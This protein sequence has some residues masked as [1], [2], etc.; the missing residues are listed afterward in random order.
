MRH[1]DLDCRNSLFSVE[2]L[3]IVETERGKEVSLTINHVRTDGSIDHC[4]FIFLNC[5]KIHRKNHIIIIDT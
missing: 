4:Q 5:I 2:L 1:R 3:L